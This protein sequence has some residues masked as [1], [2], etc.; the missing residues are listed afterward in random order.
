MKY[1]FLFIIFVGFAL[2]ACNSQPSTP[3]A[4]PLPTAVPPESVPSGEGGGWAVGFRH[5]FGPDFWEEGVHQY[6]FYIK[7]PVPGF[8]DYGSDWIT[9]EIDDTGPQVEDV[10]VYLRI[11]GVTT[12]I[13]TPNYLQDV[14]F[15]SSIPTTAVV[16]FIGMNEETAQQLTTECDGII[17]WDGNNTA[18]LI[19][20]DPF[21]P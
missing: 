12:E 8:E 19:A 16:Y 5:E 11:G 21:I 18:Q 2:I 14:S 13:F 17:N 9:F 4:T 6:G 15:H 3:L 10:T 1:S 7:C 20:S